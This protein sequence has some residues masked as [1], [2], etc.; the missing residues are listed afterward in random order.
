MSRIG[1]AALGVVAF[2]FA[3]TAAQAQE[4][5]EQGLVEIQ[6]VVSP[7]GI[8]AWL[9]QDDFVPIVAIRVGFY[10]G[11]T[12][13]VPGKEGTARLTSWLLDEGAGDMDSITFQNRLEDHAI[14]MG[15][16]AGEDRF[17]ASMQTLT[18]H[19]DE[20]FNMLRLALTQPRFDADAIER[21]RR[22][23]LSQIA[24]AERDPNTIA[25]QTFWATAFHGHRYGLPL[26][27]TRESVEAINVNDL[28]AF[29]GTLNRRDMRIGVA[30]DIDPETLGRLLDETFGDLPAEGPDYTRRRLTPD[31]VGELVVVDSPNPQSVVIFGSQGI[32]YNDPD[33]MAAMVMN[34]VLGGSSFSSRLMQTVRVQNG[35]AYSVSSSL[36]NY[37]ELTLFSGYVG[38]ENARVAESIDLIRSE[39]VRLRDEGVEP[40]ELEQIQTYLTG[41]Y[42]LGFDSNSSIANR[43][44]FYQLEDLG[45]DYINTRNPRVR[46]VTA[47]DVHRVAERLLRPEDLLIVVVGQPEGLEPTNSQ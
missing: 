39:M 40:D 37:D 4:T 42:A 33:Y 7:G 3:A 6:R 17:N 28:R 35:L 16:G 12:R 13:D 21:M 45:L 14:R 18:V 11:A 36:S 26:S 44:V 19:Q 41:A 9:V 31:G 29:H 43:L 10:G 27:G 38:T 24:Q 15:F 2:V 20:A 25:S 34:A 47:A 46:A 22:S 8:E 5:T 32:E 30:G 1:I 23:L